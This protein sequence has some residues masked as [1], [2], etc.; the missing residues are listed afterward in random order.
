MRFFF[1]SSKK[2]LETVMRDYQAMAMRFLWERGEEGSNSRDA[3]VHVNKILQD[4]GESKSR[5]SIIFFLND[6][7]DDGFVKYRERSG[8]G[9]YHRVYIP[10]Y[11]EAGFKELIARRV[12]EKLLKEF[13]DEAEKVMLKIV[14]DK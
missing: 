4:R 13:P 2:G 10:I 14:S 12:M 9:G 1:D 7:V 11:D 5:A 8:K 6:M 3:C